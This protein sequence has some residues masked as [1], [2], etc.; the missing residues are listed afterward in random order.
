MSLL[1]RTY[2][3]GS[4]FVCFG[5]GFCSKKNFPSS[6]FSTQ[7]DIFVIKFKFNYI[8]KYYINKQLAKNSNQFIL[9]HKHISL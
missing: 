6:F 4:G 5:F 3:H 2:F 9:N 7:N 1:N 8:N